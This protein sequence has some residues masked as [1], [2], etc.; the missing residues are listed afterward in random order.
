MPP[1]YVVVL[2]DVHDTARY[3]EYARRASVIEAKY[4]GRPLVAGDAVEIV[5]GDWPG[6]RTV[7]L[8]FPS[9]DAARAWYA[10]PEYQSLLPLRHE[11]TDSRI[12]FIEGFQ[13][14]T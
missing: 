11:A 9:L 2:L 3:V 4:G 12:L 1:G 6:E 7:V 13:P 10:D 14:S 5:E 8:E